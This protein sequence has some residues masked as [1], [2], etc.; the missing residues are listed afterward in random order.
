[1]MSL[2]FFP[3]VYFCRQIDC[4]G[5]NAR[6]HDANNEKVDLAVRSKIYFGVRAS[7]FH[8]RG[9]FERTRFQKLISIINA[10]YSFTV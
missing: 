6:E 3:G 10:D 4:I 1:M 9:L 7:H 8:F 5:R 2:N